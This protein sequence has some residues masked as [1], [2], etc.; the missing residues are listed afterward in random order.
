M[1]STPHRSGRFLAVALLAWVVAP[2]VFGSRPGSAKAEPP[3]VRTPV[4]RIAFGSCIRQDRPAPILETVRQSDPDLL[5]LLGDNI[6][7]DTSDMEV[8]RAKYDTLAAIPEFA[9]LRR[10]VPIL[11]TWDDHDFG[12][13]DGGAD[14]P[15]RAESREIFLRFWETPEEAPVWKHEGIYD[16]RV[17]GE[18]GRRVQII[19]LDTRYNRSPLKQA[20]RR[21]GGPYVPDADANKT[22]L[23]EAQWRWLEEQLAEPAELRILASSIQLLASDAGQETWANLPRERSRLLRMLRDRG[24]SGVIAI[25]GDRHWAELSV[26]RQSLAYPLY[27]LTSSSFNQRHPRGTPTDNSARATETTYH[28]ENFGLVE[29]DWQQEDPTIRLSIRDGEGQVRIDKRLRL[30]ELQAGRPH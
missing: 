6:Y 11:A 25:S 14:S 19:L 7:A 30:S 17:F 13:D 3:G 2:A 18:P 22:M 21:L 24:V 1:W 5:I 27:D 15:N 8:M 23:G 16:A 26:D 4:T 12:V 10:Q 28:E 20:G 9:R 29:I